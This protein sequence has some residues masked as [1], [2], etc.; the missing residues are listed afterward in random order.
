MPP[1]G[2]MQSGRRSISLPRIM[3]C[4]RIRFSRG[5]ATVEQS[6][7]ACRL[8]FERFIYIFF[9][10]FFFSLSGTVNET[11]NLGAVYYRVQ[12]GESE[13]SGRKVGAFWRPLREDAEK[14][15]KHIGREAEGSGAAGSR[16]WS[17]VGG[18]PDWAGL[19]RD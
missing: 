2:G 19:T 7:H 8:F 15:S 12:D 4:S 1:R 11:T 16:S 13:Q 10:F 6:T 9:F 5:S 17:S 18:S 14:L 3:Q